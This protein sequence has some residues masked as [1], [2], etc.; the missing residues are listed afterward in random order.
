[1]SD[2][3]YNRN[4]NGNRGRSG[5][6]SQKDNKKSY[7]N[8]K[9]EFKKREEKETKEISY[10][11]KEPKD[12]KEF[13]IELGGN[14]TERVYVPVYG[15]LSNDECLMILDKE[16]NLLIEDGDLMKEE[17]IGTE[18]T[19]DTWETPTKMRNK[20]TAI[21][22][23]NRKFRSCLKGQPRDTWLELIE[24]QTFSGENNY[25]V[26]NTYSVEN[27]YRNQKLLAERELD[28][29]CVETLKT[30]LGDTKKPRKMKIDAFIRRAKTLNNYLP[31]M[32]TRAV[33]LTER[34]MLK[35]VVL[36]NIPTSWALDLRRANNHNK[37]TL[38]EL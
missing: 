20:L 23:V 12:K 7:P 22:E 15:D 37:L 19:R 33:K 36:K 24:A 28:E 11:H 32:N 16:F 4:G 1:M 8:K 29:E 14:D 34:E 26:D 27:F 35:L 13:N 5:N 2:N 25:E 38:V 3:R 18:D 31:Q 30:Y 10:Y 6:P 17:I 21:K 9:K